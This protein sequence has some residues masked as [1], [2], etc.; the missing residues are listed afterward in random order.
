MCMCNTVPRLDFACTVVL[1][2]ARGPE[3]NDSLHNS[4]ERVAWLGASFYSL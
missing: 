3:L 2:G 4:V 1:K